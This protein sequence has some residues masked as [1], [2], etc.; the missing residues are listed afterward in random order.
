MRETLPH[1][2]TRQRW[3][4]N[5]TFRTDARA[6]SLPNVQRIEERIMKTLQKAVA[7]VFAASAMVSGA[8]IAQVIYD[9]TPRYVQANPAQVGTVESI[10]V[11]RSRDSSG[12]RAAGTILGGIVGGVV[13]HQ[14]GSGRGNDAATVAGALGGAA[15]GHEIAE[16]RSGS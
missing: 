7:A 15:V 10:D 16:N 8:T 13:G 4:T 1:P 14:F 9:S 12:N 3:G 6:R 2:A 5:V 11:V